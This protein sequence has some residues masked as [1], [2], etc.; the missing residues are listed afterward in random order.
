M[1]LNLTSLVLDNIF[2]FIKNIGDIGPML[3]LLILDL[4]NL[5]LE[6]R[7]NNISV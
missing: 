4:F 5:N 2:Y 3:G 6:Y 7:K 1:D